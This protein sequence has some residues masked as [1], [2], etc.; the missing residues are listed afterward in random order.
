MLVYIAYPYQKGTESYEAAS[1]MAAKVWASGLTAVSP[2]LNMGYFETHGQMSK[3]D[4]ILGGIDLLVRCDALITIPEWNTFDTTFCEVHTAESNDIPVYIFPDIPVMSE[5]EKTRPTQ[6]ISFMREIMSMYRVHLS[7]N[8]DYCLARGT[9][10]LTG[11]LLWVPIED[12]KPGMVI[13]GF[14]E[15]ASG[16]NQAQRMYRPSIVEAVSDVVLPSYK[17][18]LE[19]GDE[20][21]C[22]GQHPWL[23]SGGVS[24]HW[25]ITENIQPRDT[26]VIPSRLI[27]IL[28]VLETKTDYDSGYLAA[29]F[30]GEGKLNLNMG[31]VDSRRKIPVVHKEYIGNQ[32]LIALRTSTKTFVANGYATHNS[33]ANIL[34]AGNIGIVT[35]MWDKVARLMNLTGFKIEISSSKFEAPKKPK[36]ESIAD[37]VKD[38]AVYAIIYTIYQN[39]DW[40]K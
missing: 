34:G 28:D 18:T 27:K 22:S 3:D 32:P 6:C 40:G 21:V 39:G 36:N 4:Y 11:D 17:I 26:Y 16:K 13:V 1:E 19:N 7:K 33:P 30:D 10:V 8:A 14:D 24:S 20:F 5:T 12:L 15:E 37:T 9:L 31:M 38:L 35:R 23:V 2:F 29:A 25:C